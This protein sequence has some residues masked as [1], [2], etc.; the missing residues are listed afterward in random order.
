MIWEK[1]EGRLL[2]Q[3]P[4]L[5]FLYSVALGVL[6]LIARADFL[7][8][9]GR[10]LPPQVHV[11]PRRRRGADPVCRRR[12]RGGR[13]AGGGGARAGGE[14]EGGGGGGGRV[15]LGGD[16]GRRRRGLGKKERKSGRSG[17]EGNLGFGLRRIHASV[18]L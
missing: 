2:R 5:I 11:A 15:V 1:R 3:G 9:R 16:V 18:V 6:L 17:Q 13:G 7:S 14:G 8:G 12:R 4:P 10:D